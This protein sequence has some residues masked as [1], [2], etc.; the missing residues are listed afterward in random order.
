MAAGGF[1]VL[2]GGNDLIDLVL[3]FFYP[4][5]A[6]MPASD[7]EIWVW[8]AETRP[9]SS[10]LAFGGGGWGERGGKTAPGFGKD[11]PTSVSPWLYGGIPKRIMSTLVL[12]LSKVTWKQRSSRL[13]LFC[14]CTSPASR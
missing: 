1:P 14:F 8:G 4:P 11:S 3:G 6:P 12:L 5:A 9:P 13:L 7:K 10:L 2:Q